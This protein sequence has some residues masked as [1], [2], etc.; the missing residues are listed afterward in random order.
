MR[1]F[2]VVF[3]L[4]VLPSLSLADCANRVESIQSVGD[5]KAAFRCLNNEI[6]VLKQK[7]SD[8]GKIY[9]VPK[10]RISQTVTENQIKYDVLGCSNKRGKVECKLRVTLLGA[11]ASFR[12]VS[13]TRIYDENGNEHNVSYIQIGNQSDSNDLRTTLISNVPTKMILRFNGVSP[14]ARLITVLQ[15]HIAY[16]YIVSLRDIALKR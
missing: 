1:L 8:N 5:I 14:Q 12:V 15:I 16:S 10:P 6:R 13:S 9:S 11:D 4:F 3:L 7:L 2:S